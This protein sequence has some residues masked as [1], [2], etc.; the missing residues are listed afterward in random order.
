MSV[1]EYFGSFSYTS[2][3]GITG[4][5]TAVHRDYFSIINHRDLLLN[6]FG[7]RVAQLL[8]VE[9]V[10]PC[11]LNRSNNVR[12]EILIVNTHLLFPHDSTLC[13]VR[14]HQVCPIQNFCIV[15][16]YYLYPPLWIFVYSGLWDLAKCGILSERIWAEPYAYPTLR[17]SFSHTRFMSC[18]IC[19]SKVFWLQVYGAILNFESFLRQ[20]LER[21]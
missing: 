17:V 4:L 14:L 18:F 2:G 1:D 11:F 20:W 6:D 13:L 7:D 12:Q 8:H 19:F 3:L 9:L 15:L 16:F 5:L 21:K 10:S